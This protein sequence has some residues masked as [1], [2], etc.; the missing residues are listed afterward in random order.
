MPPTVPRPLEPVLREFAEVAGCLWDLGWAEASAGN[1]SADV[2]ELLKVPPS[3]GRAG[4]ALP[5]PLPALAGRSF[6]VTATGSRFRDL[7]RAP[8]DKVCLVEVSPAGDHVSWRGI[9]WNA[10]DIRPSSEL[11]SHLGIHAVLREQRSDHRAI[12]HAHPTHLA[13]L[14]HLERCSGSAELNRLLWSIHPEVKLLAPRGAT[15]LPHLVPG[16]NELGAA[17]TRA[18]RDGADTVLWR[19][20]GCLAHAPD[21]STALDRIHVLD[22]AARMVLLCLASGEPWRGLDDRE[23]AELFARYGH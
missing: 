22:K 13:T 7:R 19:Y 8:E 23:L 15:M 2:S 10:G 14:T 3:K 18:V 11:I 17:T 5:T 1:I 20:H 12:L 21:A 4:T 16:S 6:L 9:V